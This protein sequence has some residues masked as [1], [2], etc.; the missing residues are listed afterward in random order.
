[1]LAF[2]ADE[3]RLLQRPEYL[4]GVHLCWRITHRRAK[5]KLGWGVSE[6]VLY[7]CKELPSPLLFTQHKETA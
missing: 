3:F 6:N 4:P 5:E 7:E 2:A 1:M